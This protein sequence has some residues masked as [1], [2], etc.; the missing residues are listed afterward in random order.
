[1]PDDDTRVLLDDSVLQAEPENVA[2]GVT[3]PVI[4]K[5]WSR[6]RNAIQKR[7]WGAKKRIVAGKDVQRK[8]RARRAEVSESGQKSGY[9]NSFRSERNNRIADQVKKMNKANQ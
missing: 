8:R 2:R 9:K 7:N 1:M 6:T 4:Q 3:G 5:P